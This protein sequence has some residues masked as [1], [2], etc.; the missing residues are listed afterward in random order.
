MRNGCHRSRAG[1]GSALVR[2]LEEA[3]A[4]RGCLKVNV[5]VRASNAG[6]LAFYEKL[7]YGVEDRVSMGKRLYQ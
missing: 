4:A 3:L 6:V 7:G 2:R 5:Q 1:I